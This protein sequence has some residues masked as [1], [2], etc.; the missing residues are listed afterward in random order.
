MLLRE[1]YVIG[2]LVQVYVER[3]EWRDSAEMQVKVTRL[4]SLAR[5]G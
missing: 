2:G 4:Q 1:M 3:R 5:V